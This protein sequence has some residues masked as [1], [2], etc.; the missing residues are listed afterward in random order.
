MTK[1]EL[2]STSN[3]KTTSS[4]VRRL[5]ELH[6]RAKIPQSVLKTMTKAR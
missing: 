5:M 1:V 3:D 4:A 2:T 6:S